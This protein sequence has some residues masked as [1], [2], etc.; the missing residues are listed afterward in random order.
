MT[1]QELSREL[2]QLW[3]GSRPASPARG[4]TFDMKTSG[5][6]VTSPGPLEH[7]K[8]LDIPTRTDSPSRHE[9]FATG[10][11]LGLIGGVR[12]WVRLASQ[13]TTLAPHLQCVAD[14]VYC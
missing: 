7:M 2:K 5:S 8:H 4:L 3:Q 14:S 6:G 1:G 12:S 10:Y 13:T 9:D 11:S